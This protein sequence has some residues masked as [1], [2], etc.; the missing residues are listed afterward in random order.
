[1]R[2]D[3]QNL[4]IDQVRIEKGKGLENGAIRIKSHLYL[5]PGTPTSSPK[6]FFGIKICN[7]PDKIAFP[8]R[9]NTTNVKPQWP[10]VVTEMTITQDSEKGKQQQQQL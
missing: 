2:N 8:G 3:L 5:H 1:M 4:E 10:S 6:D 9:N 7:S